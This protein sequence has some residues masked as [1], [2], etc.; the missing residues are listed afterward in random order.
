[1]SRS[2]LILAHGSGQPSD[3]PW[4]VSLAQAL[5]E[6]GV[7]CRRF[8]F[9][10]MYR[11]L[12]ARKPRP[13]SALPTL[14][15]EYR[16]VLDSVVGVERVFVGG[17]SLGGRVATHLALSAPVCGVV[18]FGY[19]F[20]PPGKPEKLRSEHLSDIPCPVLIC[21]GERD[22]FGKREEIPGYNLPPNLE[23]EWIPDGDHGFKPR[24]RTGET[25]EGNLDR[26]ASAAARFMLRD[27]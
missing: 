11:A 15:E 19:P 22:T 18:A 3:S 2:I 23:F 1:M 5:G 14:V 13:P 6:Q 20:H 17:K 24:K 25:L 16:K 4:M 12:A 26:A 8:N 9:E 27:E 10:Y 21:Q 7:E